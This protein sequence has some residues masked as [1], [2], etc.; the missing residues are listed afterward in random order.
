MK[1]CRF[2]VD[3]LGVV[4]G[5]E[6]VDVSGALDALPASRWVREPGDAVVARLDALR[7]A[8]DGMIDGAP[9]R[10][11]AGVRLAAPVATPS[12]IIGAPVN[13]HAHLDEARADGA[14]HQ[15]RTVH[16]IDEIGCFLKATS[17]LAGHDDIVALPRDGTRVD[18]EAEVAVI[19]G[20]PARHVRAADAHRHVAGYALALDIS[21]RG[22]QD[23][24]MRKSCDGFAVLGPWLVTPDDVPA[25]DTIPF[26]LSVNGERRQAADTSML[27]RSVGELIEMC[28]A[29]YTLWPGDVIM[30]GTP[31]GV[32]PVVPGDVA[33]VA[34]PVLG[35]LSVTFR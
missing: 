35:S 16:P 10:P 32:A 30:T 5:D 19:I 33:T 34:S 23:R 21:V 11:R 13:Y 24:S 7:A 17:A 4:D 3:R 22:K 1:L 31:A 9:R 8:I 2:D 12:K 28:S 26:A 29:F 27:I 14:L 20:A 25:P 15:G 6:I 18:P